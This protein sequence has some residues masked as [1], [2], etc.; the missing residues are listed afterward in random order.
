VC[1]EKERK[2]EKTERKQSFFK[3]FSQKKLTPAKKNIKKKCPG[4]RVSGMGTLSPW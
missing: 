3:Y 4:T 2:R 1:T